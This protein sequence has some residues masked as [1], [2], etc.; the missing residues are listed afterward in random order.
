MAAGVFE[1]YE[2]T[3][4]AAV[5]LGAFATRAASPSTGSP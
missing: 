2:V 1:S 4:V 5:L 3:L